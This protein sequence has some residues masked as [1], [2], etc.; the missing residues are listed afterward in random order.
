[1]DEEHKIDQALNSQISFVLNE[2][3]FVLPKK[4]SGIKAGDL[5]PNCGS[6]RLDYDG[7]LNICCPDCGYILVGCFT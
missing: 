5:C 4:V 3:G 2:K 6:A 1:V 7:L